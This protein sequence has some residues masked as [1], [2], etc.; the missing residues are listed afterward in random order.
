MFVSSIP[1]CNMLN[2]DELSEEL[3]KRFGKLSET[4]SSRVD[5]SGD[6][7]GVSGNPA[8]GMHSSDSIL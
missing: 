5:L 4:V 7:V 8:Q 1:G 3:K 2:L 6:K